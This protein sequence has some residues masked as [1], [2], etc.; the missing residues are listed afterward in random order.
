MEALVVSTFDQT[1]DFEALWGLP[2]SQGEVK[3]Y[4]KVC[5]T[6]RFQQSYGR[7]YRFSGVD[8]PGKEIPPELQGLW[9][10]AQTKGK[11]NQMFLN[12][13]QDGTHYISAHRDDES[14]LVQGSYIL[15]VSFGDT[16]KFRIRDYKT[17]L[18][19]KDIDLTDGTVLE[20]RHPFNQE[21]THE[22]V[23]TSKPVGRRINVTFRQFK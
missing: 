15:S 4:G 10:W 7:G 8:H 18:I 14:E 16:R 13:Y 23:K 1:I 21:Y 2:K 12:W 20:M 5:K 11:Y 6:P 17:K 9:E 3:I 22:I 19:V